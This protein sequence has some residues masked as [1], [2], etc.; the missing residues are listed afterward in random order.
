MQKRRS[1]LGM[2][3][4]LTVAMAGS[5]LS[6][7]GFRLRGSSMA[8]NFPFQRIYVNQP[9]DSQLGADL[10]RLLDPYE[11]L[12][13]VES[14]QQAQVSLHILSTARDK[15]I[16]TLNSQGR[17]REYSLTYT[18][19]YRVSGVSGKEL[20]PASRVVANR[21]LSYNENAALGKEAEEDLLYRD[22]QIDAIQ[23]ILR[24]LALLPVTA[25]G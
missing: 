7:C 15:T 6:G 12:T 20:L 1:L 19:H 24:R 9:P 23:Q 8:T 11:G 21:T 5:Q 14:L 16:L 13:V 2:L 22:M 3:S 25:Q 10:R 18:L 4:L 17:V